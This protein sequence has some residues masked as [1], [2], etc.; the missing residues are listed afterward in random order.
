VRDLNVSKK[1]KKIISS[2][3]HFRQP[4]MLLSLLFFFIIIMFLNIQPVYAVS[5]SHSEDFTTTT[6]KDLSSTNVSGWGSGDIR[7][8][9]Q[10]PS[11]LGSYDTPNESID[12]FVS[13]D[14]VFIADYYSGLQIIDISDSG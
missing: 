4:I 2:K 13:G 1:K 5:D 6:Y 8:P 7:L 11:F 9:K 10:N 12:V 3:T 14:T